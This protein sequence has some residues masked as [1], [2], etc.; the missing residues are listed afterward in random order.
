V[1]GAA[2]T[3]TLLE[4]G[5]PA[6]QRSRNA[7]ANTRLHACAALS[8]S[9]RVATILLDSG[10]NVNATQNGQFPPLHAAAANGSFDLVKLLLERGADVSLRT[11]DGQTAADLARE[12]GH[13]EVLALLGE[14][15]S[16]A[17]AA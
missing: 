1:R 15:P 12:K 17:Q 9:A 10:A 5:A 3:A 2:A 13:Q 7:L 8:H 6:D 14:N 16:V 4:L 11:A